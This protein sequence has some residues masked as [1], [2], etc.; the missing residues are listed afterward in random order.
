MKVSKNHNNVFGEERLAH[1]RTLVVSLG[2]KLTYVLI[3]AT[4]ELHQRRYVVILECLS[5]FVVD[6]IILLFV[7]FVEL[8]GLVDA[9]FVVYGYLWLLV[10]S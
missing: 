7:A 1:I 4:T 10:F 2:V 6:D 9:F 5:Y 8:L 3:Y